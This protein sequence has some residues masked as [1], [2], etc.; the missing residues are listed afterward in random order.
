[1]DEDDNGKFRFQK[2]ID[3]NRLNPHDA[4]KY[5]LTFAK[6]GFTFLQ[7]RGFRKKIFMKLCYHYMAN[8]FNFSPTS[9][10]LYPLQIENCDNNSRHV[11]DKDDNG[12]F[13]FQRVD[14]NKS[15][16]L[17][18]YIVC[19]DLTKFPGNDAIHVGSALGEHLC[20]WRRITR[21]PRAIPPSSPHL[22]PLPPKPAYQRW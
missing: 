12:K 14:W 20:N 17:T 22:L 1:M 8:V 21:L 4:S 6:T 13:R 7:L 19:R 5:N 16:N 11:V 15:W 18:R 10:Y 3:V 2:V 9:S